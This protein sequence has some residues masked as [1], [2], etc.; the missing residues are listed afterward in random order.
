MSFLALNRVRLVLAIL[1]L[2]D[3]GYLYLAHTGSAHL[4]CFDTGCAKVAT[5]A[6]SRLWGVSIA[7]LGWWFYLAIALA[8]IF[9]SEKQGEV[10]RWW[11]RWVFL[12]CGFGFLFSLFLQG[13]SI[14]K[15]GALCFWCVLSAI[16]V[17]F[18]T[19]LS[20]RMGYRPLPLEPVP[21]GEAL[22]LFGWGLLAYLILGSLSLGYA[23]IRSN[24]PVD[25]HLLIRPSS[26][27]KGPKEA[28]V[29]MV[30]FSD[31][32]CPVCADAKAP[33]EVVYRRFQ[34]KLKF[35][36]RHFPLKKHPH[37]ELL[38]EA[39]EAAGAQGKFWEMHDL[40]FENQ[41][42][43]THLKEQELRQ[44]LLKIAQK[45][46]LN[47]EQ[48]KRDLETRRFLTVVEQDRK[49]GLALGVN[50]TPTIFIN[51]RR[52]TG[53]GNVEAISAVISGYLRLIR[54]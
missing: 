29:I 50:A 8:S 23:I 38:A 13:I 10:G 37:A 6:Y 45:I 5:S 28:P 18:L 39:A 32:E 53:E 22:R 40:L 25:P 35:V 48:F 34:G 47:V 51:G 43:L 12:L 14:F 21:R 11:D 20:W 2:L 36:Y 16:N 27:F 31:F 3:A 26:H 49:D 46:S 44:E 1:G 4:V 7:G 15:I 33:L 42:K 54:R 41:D 9:R 24:Q 30:L 17:A 19:V 52:Y